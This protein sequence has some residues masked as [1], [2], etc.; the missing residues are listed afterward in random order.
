MEIEQ[1]YQPKRAK[2]SGCL[3]NNRRK[4]FIGLIGVT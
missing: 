2:T 3:K 4:N 1:I